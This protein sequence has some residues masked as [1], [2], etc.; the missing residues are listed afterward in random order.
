MAT[1]YIGENRKGGDLKFAPGEMVI[2]KSKGVKK[3]A[4]LMG[5]S[6]SVLF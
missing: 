1:R 3:G 4:G 2:L 5:K 6:T